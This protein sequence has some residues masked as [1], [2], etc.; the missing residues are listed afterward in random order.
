MGIPVD[1]KDLLTPLDSCLSIFDQGKIQ[2]LIFAIRLISNSYVCLCVLSFYRQERKGGFSEFNEISGSLP[3]CTNYF[4][5]CM[6]S[7]SCES[8]TLCLSDGSSTPCCTSISQKECPYPDSL[9]IR[10]RKLRAVNWCSS[11][12]DCRGRSTMPT[13]CCATGCNYNMCV[14]LGVPQTPPQFRRFPIVC[15]DPYTLPMMCTVR[16][17]TS[18]CL[19]DTECPSRNS[20]HPRK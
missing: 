11:D 8:G 4:H 2:G 12:F 20:L 16:N 3:L 13:K 10:C 1:S 6:P 18:W 15:P 5:S 17:P 7:S 19:T 9:N 14:N